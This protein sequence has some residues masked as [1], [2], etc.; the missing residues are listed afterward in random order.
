MADEKQDAGGRAIIALTVT[1][2]LAWIAFRPEPV[3]G[4][5]SKTRMEPR[6]RDLRRRRMR[7]DPWQQ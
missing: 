2:L 1:G 7:R 3:R 6:T 4:R 5:A